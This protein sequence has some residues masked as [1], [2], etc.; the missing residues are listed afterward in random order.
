M[1][2]HVWWNA[3][4]LSRMRGCLPA[5]RYLAGCYG[6]RKHLDRL[7]GRVVQ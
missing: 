2:T 7:L 4:V 1:R 6:L 3:Y 5:L